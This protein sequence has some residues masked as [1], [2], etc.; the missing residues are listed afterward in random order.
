MM[1]EHTPSYFISDKKDEIRNLL[2]EVCPPYGNVLTLAG[3]MA[4]D[5]RLFSERKHAK[6]SII[7]R[8][9]EAYGIQTNNTK[10]N[11]RIHRYFGEALDVV[12]TLSGLVEPFD[13]I[14]L[15]FCGPYSKSNEDTIFHTMKGVL[16]C[17][18]Y[19]A[20][21][22]LIGR[23]HDIEQTRL[24]SKLERGK[25]DYIADRVSAIEAILYHFSLD[26]GVRINI[27]KKFTYHNNDADSC[28]MIFFLVRRVK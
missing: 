15:D 22:F 21:T 13:L 23:E 14:Y 4:K 12:K 1:K 20:L 5:A 2:C 27:E 24:A 9:R 25:H 6:V 19:L 28:E 16:A 11:P 17:Q 7:E 8:D 18:G 26:L 10:D 3:P